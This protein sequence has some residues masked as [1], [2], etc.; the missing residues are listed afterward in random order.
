MELNN[1][2]AIVTGSAIRLGR[3]ISLDLSSKGVQLVAHYHSSENDAK[4][5][6]QDVEAKGGHISLIK[7]DLRQKEAPELLLEAA[8][9]TFGDVHILI[10]NAALFYKTPLGQVTETDWDT[11]HELNLKR[12]FFLT[13]TIAVYMKS[14][15]AGKI[16]NIGDT[17]ALSPWPEYIPYATSKAGLISMTVG[18]AKALAPEIQVNCVN[19]GPVMMPEDMA[20]EERRKAVE[21]TLLKREGA[22]EDIART[23]RFLLEGSDYITGAVIPVDGGRH[24]R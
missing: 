8:L 11:F 18:L 5:L 14:T 12:I 21:Q 6:Q 1:K 13:Q 24:I 7:A 19:P 22:P 4:Q 16:I 3:A 15:G 2:V 20:D 10:N 23:V 17:S 9:K